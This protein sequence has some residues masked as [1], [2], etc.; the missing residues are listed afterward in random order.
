MNLAE[1]SSD[2][3][4]HYNRNPKYLP[5]IGKELLHAYSTC[6]K[7][8]GGHCYSTAV[9]PE[10]S[11]VDKPRLLASVNTN[12]QENLTMHHGEKTYKDIKWRL[13]AK[14]TTML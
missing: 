1:D 7:P 12:S 10:C 14:A 2:P 13:Q 5:C 11:A 3:K 4:P 8:S 6:M 9:H